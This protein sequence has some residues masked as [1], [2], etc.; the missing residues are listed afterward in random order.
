MDVGG[1]GRRGWGVQ[2]TPVLGHIAILGDVPQKNG[3]DLGRKVRDRLD[4]SR[5]F[6]KH[7]C[8]LQFVVSCCWLSK[9]L[10]FYECIFLSLPLTPTFPSP[11]LWTFDTDNT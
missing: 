6:F 3:I 11:F 9:D 7:C 10:S 2:L 8:A 5:H 4:L 1:G